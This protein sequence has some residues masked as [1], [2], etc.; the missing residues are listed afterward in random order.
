MSFYNTYE[1]YLSDME[2]PRLID[3]E[4][5]TN[6]CAY[7]LDTFETSKLFANKIA[8]FKIKYYCHECLKEQDVIKQINNESQASVLDRN[9]VSFPACHLGLL[10]NAKKA[11]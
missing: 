2:R 5:D 10:F 6:K 3:F 8:P 11:K 1:H 7:C 4:P 9:S